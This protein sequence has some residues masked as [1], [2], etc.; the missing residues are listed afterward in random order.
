L[1]IEPQVL[2]LAPE[3]YGVFSL[4]TPFLSGS[5]I[6]ARYNPNAERTRSAGKRSAGSIQLESAQAKVSA[7]MNWNWQRRKSA[8]LDVATSH[9]D[10]V[11]LRALIDQATGDCVDESDEH[12]GLLSVIREEVACP[13]P[14]RVAGEDV[15]CIRFEWP[16]NGY[17]LNAAC[18]S[19]S[20]T[21]VV[22][23][24]ALEWVE[25]LPKGHEWIEAYFA[26]RDLLG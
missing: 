7:P 2:V 4:R 22:D 16:K 24:G 5:S 26:W 3:L 25:P 10:R 18:K 19:K 12:A 9:H 20:K 17:G 15:E 1:T 8:T 11:K 14:A 13:F 6:F 23:I 21:F